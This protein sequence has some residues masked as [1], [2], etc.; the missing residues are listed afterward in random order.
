MA[1]IETITFDT[2]QWDFADLEDFEEITGLSLDE[3]FSP[4]PLRDARGEVIRDPKNRP[5]KGLRLNAKTMLAIVFIE[6]RKQ[7]PEFTLDDA[8]RVKFTE[9]SLDGGPATPPESDAAA[10]SD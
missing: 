3:A 9:F 6:K 10:T 7:N 5:V 2:D 8:R 4:T 1:D